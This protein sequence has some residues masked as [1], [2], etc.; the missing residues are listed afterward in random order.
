MKGFNT[1]MKRYF[2]QKICII[3]AALTIPSTALLC[4]LVM[5]V[6]YQQMPEYG[7]FVT[8]YTTWTAYYKQ[9]DMTLANLYIGGLLGFFLLYAVILTLL[10]KK[11][12][13]LCGS[14]DRTKEYT[15]KQRES[16]AWFEDACFLI[17]FSEFLLALI[18]FV[19][20]AF[21]GMQPW[22]EK[23]FPILQCITLIGVGIFTNF[24]R[25][26]GKDLA[27]QEQIRRQLKKYWSGSSGFCRF[28][29]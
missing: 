17:L 22:F 25:R 8:G 2:S 9:G 18:C 1:I 20:E 26:C 21:F 27:K 12:S 15:A 28:R 29:S 11:W 24:V 4:W 6:L 10:S 14:F 23:L 3:S 16:Y 13:W 7:E 5:R 19:I